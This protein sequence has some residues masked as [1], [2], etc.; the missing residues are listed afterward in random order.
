MPSQRVA[1]ARSAGAGAAD[2][3]WELWVPA[4]GAQ[5][6]G[7]ADTPCFPLL[8]HDQCGAALLTPLPCTLQRTVPGPCWS[9]G[10][11]LGSVGLLPHLCNSGRDHTQSRGCHWLRLHLSAPGEHQLRENIFLWDS[12]AA[13]HCQLRAGCCSHRPHPEAT[14]ILAWLAGQ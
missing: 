2:A 8:S 3:F 13:T 12:C 7:V 9:S 6:M 1:R 10:P 5:V 4:S 14:P 11:L